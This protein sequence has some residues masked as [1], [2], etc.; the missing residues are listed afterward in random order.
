MDLPVFPARPASI[1]LSVQNEHLLHGAETYAY[2]RPSADKF[3]GYTM[4]SIKNDLTTGKERPIW[5]LASY[6]PAKFEPMLLPGLDES[7]EE[8]RLKAAS[9]MKAGNINEYLAYESSKVAAAEQVVSNALSNLFQAHEQATN[10]SGSPINAIVYNHEQRAALLTQDL[11]PS[12]L[13]NALQ[14]C[15]QRIYAALLTVLDSREAKAAVLLL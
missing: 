3:R 6:A 7:P 2:A 14:S 1:R 9:A 12:D 8:L 13:R 10:N 15:Y 4:E 5:P 11:S